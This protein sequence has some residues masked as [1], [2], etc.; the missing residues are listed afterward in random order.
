[1]EDL[2]CVRVG[3]SSCCQRRSATKSKK[4]KGNLKPE[5]R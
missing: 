3:T 4:D 5:G 1:M 2:T